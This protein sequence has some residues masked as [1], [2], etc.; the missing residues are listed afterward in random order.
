MRPRH[1][2]AAFAVVAAALLCA[3]S[4]TTTL[5]N[6]ASLAKAGQAAASQMEQNATL[7]A[8]T[9]TAL[10]KA[11]MFDAAFAGDINDPATNDFLSQE[12]QI[13]TKLSAYGTMLDKLAAAYAALGDLA[14]Y[15]ASA[16]VTT[17]VSGLCGSASTLIKT[18]SPKEQ[19]PASAC[20]ASSTGGGLLIG[21]VQAQQVLDSSAAIEGNLQTVIPI[22]A[23]QTTRDLIVMNSELVQRQIVSAAN[24]LF[25]AGAYSCGPML[26]DLGAPLSLKSTANVDAV[27]AKNPNLKRACQNYIST[28]AQDAVASVGT[29]YDKSVA[30]L[31][32][33]VKQHENLK[34][35]LPLNLDTINM[36]LTSLQ[37]LATKL[38]PSKGT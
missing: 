14:S 24:H 2:L 10:K 17:A 32:A 37:G 6:G 23:D 21:A 28:A 25:A 36:I 18:L 5:S 35:G 4:S 3:C 1:S 11:V 9:Y 31:Q 20:S 19:V 26:D 8:A 22:L 12:T 34:A 27:V 15:G 13:Q 29:S 16:N 30:G 38:Q 7:T 33:L